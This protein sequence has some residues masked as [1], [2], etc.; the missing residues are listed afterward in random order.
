MKR[1][2]RHGWRSS[3]IVRLFAF[4]TQ[5]VYSVISE[6]FLGRVFTS[7]KAVNEKFLAS[8]IG[9]RPHRRRSKGVRVTLRRNVATAMN[10]SLILRGGSALIQGLYRCSLRTI[11][12]FLSTAGLY[13]ALMYW[14]LSVIWGNDL[15]GAMSLFGGLS[16]LLVGVPMLFSDMSLG[17]AL[18]KGAFFGK[19]MA[20]VFG[21]SDYVLRDIDRQ[22]RNRYAV[23]VSLGMVVGAVSALISPFYL[24]AGA[25]GAL[26]VL[27]VLSV[28]EAGVMLL[29][30]FLPFAGFLPNGRE[31][32]IAAAV[33]PLVSYLGK[34]LRGNRSFH[35]ELQDLPV[36]VMAVLF[37]LSGIS[38]AQ[39]GVWHT[40]LTG[41][42]MACVYLFIVNVIATPRWLDRCRISLL[43]SATAAALLGGVQFIIAVVTGGWSSFAELGAAVHAGFADR[44]TFAYFLTLAFPF[45]LSAFVSVNRKYRFPAGFAMLTVAGAVLLTWV[46]SAMIAVVAMVLIFL[47]LHDRR[48]F[49]F[50]LVGTGLLPVVLAILPNRARTALFAALRENSG[51]AIARSLSAGSFAGQVFFENGVGLFDRSAGLARFFFGLGC[52]GIEQVCALYTT[53]PPAMIS[54]SLNFWLYRML[55]GGLLGV[56]VPA[57]FFFL[58]YQNGFSMLRCKVPKEHRFSAISGIVMTSGL[59]I[60]SIFRYAWYDPAALAFF[61]IAAA[62]V[63]AD[64]R[65]ARFRC[66]EEAPLPKDG[67]VAEFDYYG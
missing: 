44:T 10:R 63:A 19:L 59:L 4:V 37:L 20:A 28:P 40:A 29:I 55:E 65:Y 22:G 5:F 13:A 26:V 48:T 25:I 49:P 3:Y 45:T 39:G 60:L 47:L 6:G 42:L 21:V 43:V 23:A 38:I 67:S 7:Y 15:V 41:A 50:V 51:T 56:L 16:L 53:L 36:A 11:G 24:L 32:L 1:E 66:P 14:L 12:L 46:Q 34:L 17:H 62:I 33:L 27:L 2:S 8:R 52:G 31:W 58:L 35:I 54:R 57:A 9:S 30:V 18:A 61:F 64:A